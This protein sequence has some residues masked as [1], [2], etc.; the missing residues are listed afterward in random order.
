M[1]AEREQRAVHGR[2]DWR[3]K[4]LKREWTTRRASHG[5]LFQPWLPTSSPSQVYFKSIFITA[6]ALLPQ[7]LKQAQTLP[8][9]EPSEVLVKNADLRASG[10]T[11]QSRMASAGDQESS[12]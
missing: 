2:S 10:Q 5:R 9:P 4:D 12:C 7:A 8:V 6:S 3:E 11:F 1:V